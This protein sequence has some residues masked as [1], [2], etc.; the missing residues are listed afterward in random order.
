MVMDADTFKRE[1][2]PHH[3]LLYRI[4]YRLTENA[5][6]AQDMVQ[7]AYARLW[8]K[9]TELEDVDN[10]KAFAVTVLRNICLDNLRK[11]KNG[12]VPINDELISIR[13]GSLS[14]D[15]EQ[16]DEA[17]YIKEL[18]G[19]LPQQQRVVMILK[20][21]DNYSDEEIEEMTG[22]SRVNIRVILS[23]ARKTIKEQFYRLR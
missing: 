21:W 8:D 18:V 4:A 2:L 14:V 7:E 16:K 15:I 9:R 23:R 10:Y 19:R 12:A 6:V 11:T 5:T 1:L 22:L 13:E 20:H 3:Q 17:G